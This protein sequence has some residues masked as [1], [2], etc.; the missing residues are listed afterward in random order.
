MKPEHDR[1]VVLGTILEEA[2]SDESSAALIR[3]LWRYNDHP[4]SEKARRFLANGNYLP[5]RNDAGVWVDRKIVEFDAVRR[6]GSASALKDFIDRY[7]GHPLAF[8]AARI[9]EVGLGDA[10]KPGED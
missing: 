2:A 10:A 7:P 5:A 9:I 8:E 1:E 4:L 6:N 3:F